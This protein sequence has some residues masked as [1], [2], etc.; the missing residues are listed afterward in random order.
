MTTGNLVIGCKGIQGKK[1]M[2]HTPN[3]IGVDVG[4]LW[5]DHKSYYAG[6]VCVPDHAKFDICRNLLEAGKHVMV[7]K[8]ALFTDSQ[9]D[10]IEILCNLKQLA[11]YTAYNHRF[12]PH[13]QEMEILALR[14][15]SFITAFY[16]NGTAH[17]VKGTWRDYGA[18]CAREIGVHLLDMLYMVDGPFDAEWHVYA[19]T[20]SITNSPD[21]VLFGTHGIA[22]ETSWIS[23]LNDFRFNVIFSNESYHAEGFRKWN[24]AS[25][26]ERRV[27]GGKP[28]ENKKSWIGQDTTWDD[29]YRYF[30]SSACRHG[31]N[32]L[33]RDRWIAKIMRQ[34]DAQL[35]VE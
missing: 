24:G 27:T 19:A 28:N 2:A 29:E 23:W 30:I 11:F 4:D 6:I 5:P 1:R 18:G 7:E 35:G 3:V 17:K 33:P 32:M 31:M 8:P 13:I 10:E 25:Y 14:E 9:F 20:N 21:Y 26:I 34:I 22:L 12:E 15:S 16:G